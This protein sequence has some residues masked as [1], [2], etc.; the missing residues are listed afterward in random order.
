LKNIYFSQNIVNNVK[1]DINLKF[2]KIT[3]KKE[4]L[5]LKLLFF[6]IISY[7]ESLNKLEIELNEIITTLNLDSVKDFNIFLKK[8]MEKQIFFEIPVKSGKYSGS[9]ALISS[10]II[11]TNFCQIF[12]TDEFKYCF[13]N[14]RNIFSLLEIEKFIFMEEQISFSLYN[15]IIKTAQNKK[16]F[17]IP[18]SSLKEYLNST[19]KYPRFFDFERYVL[20]KAISD[21]NTFTDFNVEYKKIKSGLKGSNKITTINFTINKSRQIPVLYDQAIY[22]MLEL[23]KDRITNP[24]KIYNLF[25]MYSGKKG[26]KYVYDNIECLKNYSSDDF[27]KKLKKALLLDLASKK[28]KLYI[29]IN[30]VVKSPVILY[31]ILMQ[32][33][34][35]IK[36]YYPKID[37]LQYTTGVINLKN[38]RFFKDQDI[39]EF[40]ND[41]IEIY[42]KYC[43][44]K[45]SIIRVYLP[46][47]IIKKLGKRGKNENTGS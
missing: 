7:P 18:L 6:K 24:E 3:T 1:S 38:I 41:E 9:F 36:T 16:E 47:K 45:K 40:S 39:F 2:S 25:L 5:F 29:N 15:N 20:K 37:M 4:R 14:Q 32:N 34:N 10:F 31:N 42:V 35:I 22:R 11:N 33:I 43:L 23:V 8:L 12:F 28:L 27:E 21:I 13:S 17:A 19:D 30:E 44:N 46:D 26:H